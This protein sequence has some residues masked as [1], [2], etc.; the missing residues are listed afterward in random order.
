MTKDIDP[1]LDFYIEAILGKK[2]FNVVALDVAELTSYADVF[3]FCSGRSNR[4]VIAIA[5][6]IQ[7][8]LKKKHEIKPISVEGT[9]DGHWVLMDYGHVIIHVFYEPIREFYDLEG[10]WVDAKRIMTPVLE[11]QNDAE[12]SSQK[13]ADV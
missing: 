8:T 10:L 1:S 5:D 7:A 3:I 12:A 11:K 9:K 4:Q 13:M 2:T 6:N